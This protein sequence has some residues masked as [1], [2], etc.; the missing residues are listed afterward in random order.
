MAKQLNTNNASQQASHEDETLILPT[1]GL[2][3]KLEDVHVLFL[4]L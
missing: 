4:F 2:G 1:R 3:I